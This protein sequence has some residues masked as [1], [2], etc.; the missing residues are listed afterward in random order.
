MIDLSV[1]PEGTKF[2][3]KDE[4]PVLRLPGGHAV[5]AVSGVVLQKLDELESI[6]REEFFALVEA[7]ESKYG[8]TPAAK[9]ERWYGEH[10][11]TPPTVRLKD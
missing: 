9:T 3:A 1:L 10:R 4:L 8:P 11:G 5:S 2:F 7:W 6:S